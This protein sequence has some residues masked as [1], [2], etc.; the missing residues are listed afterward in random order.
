MC[1]PIK[2][3]KAKAAR[4]ENS[5][6]SESNEKCLFVLLRGCV[7]R[8]F[9]PF[10]MG[11]GQIKEAKLRASSL[12]QCS[13]TRDLCCFIQTRFMLFTDNY[14]AH[15]LRYKFSKTAGDAYSDTCRPM[16]GRNGWISL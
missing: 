6:A 16:C 10:L 5:I 4:K 9:S 13:L 3:N 11:S 1:F 2:E 14:Y 8:R 7:Y 12:S 15:T